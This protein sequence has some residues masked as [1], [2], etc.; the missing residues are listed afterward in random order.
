MRM[1]T[2]ALVIGATIGFAAGAMIPGAAAF[3]P[4]AD[5]QN[6]FTCPGGGLPVPGHPGYPGIET[7][8]YKSYFNSGGQAAAA[9]SAT[10]LFGGPLEVC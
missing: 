3:E 2:R 6:T 5:P 8:T 4:P 9:W 10:K 7:G 1:R